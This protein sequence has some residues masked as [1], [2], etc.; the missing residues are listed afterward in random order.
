MSK[1]K[2]TKLPGKRGR[3]TKL[4]GKR[5]RG[6]KGGVLMNRRVSF[7]PEQMARIRSV[8]SFTRPTHPARVGRGSKRGG[9]RWGN[10]ANRGRVVGMAPMRAIASM[11]KPAM[12]MAPMPTSFVR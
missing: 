1:G 5:G 6:K 4:P 10:I 2:G 7:R 9:G 3:G 12:S 11:P 8:R